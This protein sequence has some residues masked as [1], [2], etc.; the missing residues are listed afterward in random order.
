MIDVLHSWNSL[1]KAAPEKDKQEFKEAR[2]FL[3]VFTERLLISWP[4]V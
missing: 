3:D 2:R 1:K 4:P